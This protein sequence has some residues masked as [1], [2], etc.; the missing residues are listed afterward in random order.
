MPISVLSLFSRYAYFTAASP[1]RAPPV[2]VTGARANFGPAGLQIE[3]R[4]ATI[5]S[6][7][8]N[9]LWLNHALSNPPS[10]LFGACRV[11]RGFRR[12]TFFL[13]LCLGLVETIARNNDMINQSAIAIHANNAPMRCFVTATSKQRCMI[14]VSAWQAAVT[15]SGNH[16]S[17]LWRHPP[18]HS[19]WLCCNRVTQWASRQ[20]KC[21]PPNSLSTRHL[22]LP[23]DLPISHVLFSSS[24]LKRN[25]KKTKFNCEKI[26]R[27]SNIQKII[28]VSILCSFLCCLLFF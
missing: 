12:R 22:Y 18:D 10:S 9:T 5:C 16:A 1:L 24:S 19:S 3:F 15:S 27:K 23:F 28:L 25:K 8:Q 20:R 26:L 6:M 13:I 4:V 14:S 11:S 2:F 7:S 21:Y 17:P